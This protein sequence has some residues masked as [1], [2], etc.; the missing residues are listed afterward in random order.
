[1]KNVSLISAIALTTGLVFAQEASVQPAPAPA[2]ST[3]S[4][5]PV[6]DS[7]VQ[8]PASAPVANATPDSTVQVPVE[9]PVAAPATEAPVADST[10]QEQA[11]LSIATA[12][13]AKI[14][15]VA[16]SD[17]AALP[18]VDSAALRRAAIIDSIVNQPLD[19]AIVPKQPQT[20]MAE[21]TPLKGA[22]HDFIKAD[23]SPYVVTEDITVEEDNVLVIE[24]GVVMQFAPGTGLYVKGQL[25]VAGTPLNNVVF[26]SAVIPAQSGDWKGI[27][28]TGENP[29]EIRNATING[30]VT[31]LVVENGSLKLHSSKI[32]ETLSRGV[33]AKNSRISISGSQIIKN[34]GA[35]VHID[36]YSEAKLN[37]VLF[38]ENNIALYNAPLAITHVESS[39]FENNSYGL[40]DMANSYLAFNNTKVNKNKVGAST[41]D[42]LERNI[43]ESIHDNDIDYTKDNGSISSTLSQSPEF[44]GVESRPVIATDK[45]GDLLAQ[46][47]S[48]DNNAD[49]TQKAW[50][51]YGNVMID[52]HYHHVLTRKNHGK[53]IELAGDT[54]KRGDRFKNTFQIPGF[55]TDASIYLMMQ[56]ADGKS[57]EFNTEYTGDSWDHFSP[58]IVTLIYSDNYNRLVVGD[59]NKNGGEI[60][61]DALPVFGA[62]YT[63]SLLKNNANQPL[64]ELDGFFGENRKPYLVGDRQPTL[65]KDYV[66]EGEAQAQRITYGGSL[67]WAPLRRFDAKVGFIYANDEIE[68]PLLRDGSTKSY[69]TSEPMQQS[70]TAYADGNWLFYPGDIELN[71]QIA[72]GHADTVDVY[73]ERAINSVFQKA[74]IN[75]ASMTKLRQLMAYESKISTLSNDELE[76][77]FGDNTTLRPSQMKDSLRTLIREAKKVQKE[78]ESDRDDDRVLGLNWGS[79]DIALGASLN[80]NIYK[81]S[82]SGHIKYVGA[83]YYSAGSADQLANTREFGGNIEQEVSNFWTFNFGYQINVEN[84]ANGKKTNL[85][86]LSEG[87]HWGLF[88]DDDSKWFDKHERD[89]ERA[90]YIQ[91]WNLNNEFKIGEMLTLNLGYNLEYRTQYRP[92]QLHGN[93]IQEDG[94]YKD[95]WFA[96]RGARPTTKI[97]D[98]GDTTLVDYDRWTEYQGMA[99]EEN[100]ASKFQERICKHSWAAGV[101]VQ[102][103]KTTFKLGGRWTL[104]SDHSKFYRDSLINRMK[105]SDETIAKMGYYFGGADFFEQ[106]Y[107]ISASSDLGKIKNS[108][109]ATPRIKSYERDDMTEKEI[110]VSDDFEVSFM[111]RFL[112]AGLSGEFRYMVTDWNEEDI[113]FNETEIDV[114][115]TFNLTVNH[116]RRLSSDWYVGSA[117]YYRP[118]DL[119]EEYKDIF[120][121]IRVNYAF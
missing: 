106:T 119:S 94:V 110:S 59:F 86:G 62:G 118:D 14:D 45:V 22:I 75:T 88:G 6:A 98:N 25:V 36:S 48:Q 12:D 95:S 20:K 60:Y 33:Y 11:P 89:S 40:L 101:A 55:G 116:T 68:D 5:N 13:S 73:R 93:Y 120:G 2:A 19:S 82:I 92:Y 9:A 115:G 1:M 32:E 31:G 84:A 28:V 96:K 107:P 66:E 76:E 46:S 41:E 34:K 51:F 79:Q 43:L 63:L 42:I 17:S 69:L 56:S 49:S 113:D 50:S 83:N 97:I 3:V 39:R 117:L 61:M 44:P 65:Y 80:W 108:I 67:K 109:M 47:E 85:I 81:T 37:D 4:T 23:R 90:K 30:A 58:D 77:I 53:D 18:Q 10:V 99:S 103:D 64:L 105:L 15:S 114:L 78:Y 111:K 24:P 57:I 52:N 38:E 91:N 54:I 35:A 21:G 8:D 72:V 74:S 26:R 121:G 27:F 100:L 112:I 102:V 71:G 104:R 70:L 29:S 7:V 87:T 16:S